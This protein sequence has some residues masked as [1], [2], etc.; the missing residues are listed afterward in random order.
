MDLIRPK[1]EEL[2][3]LDEQR[4]QCEAKVAQLNAEIGEF[5]EAV[6]R[7]LPF[8]QE[9]EANIEQLNKKILELNNQQMSLRATFQ[10]MREKSTQMDNEISKAEFDLVETVQ[11]NANLRSQIVQSPDKLQVYF[12]SN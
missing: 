6:E 10:K 5:D 3:L 8:V 9:L 1:A 12:Y 7:D 4:K 2:G 11:E